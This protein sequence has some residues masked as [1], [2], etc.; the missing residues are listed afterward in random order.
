M[1]AA[2][3]IGYTVTGVAQFT[4]GSG[5]LGIVAAAGVG[6]LLAAA[7]CAYYLGLALLVNSSWNRALFPIGGEP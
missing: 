7:F 4:V 3:C 6:C 2:L 1:L 5:E